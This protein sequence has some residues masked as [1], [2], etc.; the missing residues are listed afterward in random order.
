M[1]LSSALL[2]LF[3]GDF[4]GAVLLDFLREGVP[5]LIGEING[6]LF[7]VLVAQIVAIIANDFLQ[8]I[9]A[10]PE[11]PHEGVPL[12]PIPSLDNSDLVGF[13][14][15]GDGDCVGTFPEVIYM[16]LSDPL[17]TPENLAHKI[18]IFDIMQRNKNRIE[19]S[20]KVDEKYGVGQSPSYDHHEI[21]RD[22]GIY[23]IE[24]YNIFKPSEH[25]FIYDEI[26]SIIKF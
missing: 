20:M 24:I 26:Y 3:H 23:V 18:F 25:T 2:P 9:A 1:L 13:G 12:F 15:A 7:G 19:L 5:V 8:T 6:L 11:I 14:V 17:T 4:K 21:M 10:H 16:A 22:A